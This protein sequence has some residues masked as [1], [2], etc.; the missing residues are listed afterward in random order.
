MTAEIVPASDPRRRGARMGELTKH[1]IRS[2]DEPVIRAYC[3]LRFLIMNM[4]IMEEIEQ[5]LPREGTILDVGCGFGYFSVLFASCAPRRRMIGFDAD[6]RRIEIARRVGG[7]LGLDGRVDFRRCDV[8]D[9]PFEE[10]VDAIFVLDLLHHLPR[11]L[12]PRLVRSFR[13]ALADDGVLVVKDV[14]R[15]PRHKLLFTWLLDRLHY[16]SGPLNYF[17][18]DEMLEMI[19]GE[20]FDVKHH[21]LLDVLP[22]PH[23]MYVC[24]KRRPDGQV[25]A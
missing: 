9:Y 16:G 18:R 10:R 25:T 21:H 12:A 14:T 2:Y 17:G 1:V 4:R 7:R 23:V 20:G 19:G 22:Y 6:P 5:Y 11:E 8:A 24:R 15:R 13:R 3:R